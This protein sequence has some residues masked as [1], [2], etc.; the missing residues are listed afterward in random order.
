MRKVLIFFAVFFLILFKA[1]KENLSSYN[2]ISLNY[3]FNSKYFLFTEVQL[4]GIEDFSYPDYYELKG[5]IGYNLTKNH[6]PLIGI[7]RYVNY[8]EKSLSKEEFRIFLQDVI[9]LNSGIFKFENRFRAEQS[10]FYEPKKSAHSKRNRFRYRLNISAPL[11]SKKVEK[12]TISA[13]IYDEVFFVIPMKPSFA[14]N[15]F[16]AGLSYQFN[17]EISLSSGYLW[18][19]EFGVISNRNFHFLYL[20]FS[21]NLENLKEKSTQNL[22]IND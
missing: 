2:A 13:N 4:R 11:N 22:N 1:Q 16:F 19:R 10:W 15:R 18:Q 14:R 7:G 17:K 12:G 9:N 5:G 3:Q 21:I 8:T 6:K 20:A